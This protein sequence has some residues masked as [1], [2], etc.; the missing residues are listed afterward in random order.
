M[1]KRIVLF[2]GGYKNTVNFIGVTHEQATDEA[3]ANLS[4]RLFLVLKKN[5]ISH[6]RLAVD[7]TVDDNA[8]VFELLSSSLGVVKRC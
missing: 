6:E 4:V 3:E 1:Q 2:S 7:W 5:G 8:G